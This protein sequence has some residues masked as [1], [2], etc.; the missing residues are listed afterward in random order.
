MARADASVR[1]HGDCSS[2]FPLS[3][4]SPV[5]TPT[6]VT[7]SPAPYH[8]SLYSSGGLFLQETNELMGPSCGYNSSTNTQTDPFT[9]MPTSKAQESVMNRIGRAGMAETP[10]NNSLSEAYRNLGLPTT[11]FKDETIIHLYLA[12]AEETPAQKATLLDSLRT[13]AEHKHSRYIKGFLAMAASD[14][15]TNTIPPKTYSQIP[16]TLPKIVETMVPSDKDELEWAVHKADPTVQDPN[17]EWASKKGDSL[18]PLQEP[19]KT[20]STSSIN[21]NDAITVNG[22]RYVKAVSEAVAKPSQSADECNPFAFPRTLP[23]RSDCKSA[24]NN[25]VAG[26]VS[27]G[28]QEGT[29]GGFED[30]FPWNSG[31]PEIGTVDKPIPASS[32]CVIP[33]LISQCH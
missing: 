5:F 22:I 24:D 6:T 18:Q 29:N 20:A 14:T 9:T 11:T 23:L 32:M 15:S 2:S 4:N 10:G 13:I 3:P 8:Q 27:E 31:E 16:T 28:R 19:T 30:R 12:R 33:C 17:F 7:A 26:G 1:D 25:C 21:E